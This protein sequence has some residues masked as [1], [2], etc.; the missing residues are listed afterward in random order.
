[1]S[2]DLFTDFL[3]SF[4]DDHFCHMTNYSDFYISLYLKNCRLF[5]G[6]TAGLGVKLFCNS[7]QGTF[8]CVEE[9]VGEK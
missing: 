9:F 8:S 4:L 1:M 7:I 5:S 6:T 3:V 2:L